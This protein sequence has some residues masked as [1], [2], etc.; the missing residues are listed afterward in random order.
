MGHFKKW[1]ITYGNSNPPF[2]GLM[3]EMLVVARPMPRLATLLLLLIIVLRGLIVC[4]FA[5]ATTTVE[6][7]AELTATV[8]DIDL[9]DRLV[10]L[11]R[12]DGG[13]TVV[14]VDPSI[15]RLDEIREGEK[16]HVKY[17]R[18]IALMILKSQSK[19]LSTRIISSYQTGEGAHPEAMASQ[20]VRAI[21]RIDAIDLANNTVTFTGQSGEAEIVFFSNPE[22][23]NNLSKLKRGDIAEIVYTEPTAVLVLPAHEL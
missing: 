6:D 17:S 3:G 22:L 7:T 15:R 12:P 13:F 16:V 20:L 21:V 10:I 5:L 1:A 19:A 8:R 9:A 23:R 18:A 11:E 2:E 14:A 4:P